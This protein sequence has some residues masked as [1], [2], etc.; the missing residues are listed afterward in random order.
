MVVVV[1]VLGLIGDSS[2][3]AGVYGDTSDGVDVLVDGYG[4]DGGVGGGYDGGGGCGCPTSNNKG[5][6]ECQVIFDAHPLY[7]PSGDLSIG[8]LL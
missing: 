8:W 5:L 4:F 3:V 2:G 1:V 7:P 6:I